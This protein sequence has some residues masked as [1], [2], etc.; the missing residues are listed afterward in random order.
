MKKFLFVLRS[1]GLTAVGVVI[2]IV[3]TSLLHE[4]FSLFLGP[5][6]MTDLAAADWGGRSDIM[7]QY[8]LENPSAVYTMLVAHAFGA[9]FAVYWSA[10]TAQV[11]SWRTHKGI[12]P[13]TGVIVLVALWVYGDLQ[14]DLI[15]VP[16]GIFWTSIDVVSTLLVS[17]LAFLLA[18]GFRKH[19]G[20]ARVTNDE[21][22]YRG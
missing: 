22:V 14:N 21:D 20:P 6:P 17:L 13:F 7:S 5:L 1:I 3:V 10:R 11:P 15:N 2:A 4:F 8:M 18:G 9:G 16:V 12:K 19:E